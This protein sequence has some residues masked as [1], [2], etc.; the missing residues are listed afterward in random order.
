MAAE[1]PASGGSTTVLVSPQQVPYPDYTNQIANINVNQRR[2]STNEEEKHQTTTP[3]S[4][5]DAPAPS[6]NP[7]QFSAQGRQLYV[8]PNG[9]V[10][11]GPV[12]QQTSYPVQYYQGV[13][14]GYPSYAVNQYGQ[15]SAAQYNSVGAQSQTPSPPQPQRSPSPVVMQSQYINGSAAQGARPN[16]QQALQYPGA[17]RPRILSGVL[18]NPRAN[19]PMYMPMA[20]GQQAAMLVSGQYSS[21]MHVN[22]PGYPVFRVT[23]KA[24]GKS[25]DSTDYQNVDQNMTHQARNLATVNQ[26]R[27]LIQMQP[28]AYQPPYSY[29]TQPQR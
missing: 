25:I 3:T 19:N 12:Y 9:R 4:P 23:D 10:A 6:P 7:A 11:P 26:Q 14:G 2:S 8:L 16:F 28:T 29:M 27:P 13:A 21:T 18:S 24:T 17:S 5:V 20:A 1:Q 22:T 15:Q